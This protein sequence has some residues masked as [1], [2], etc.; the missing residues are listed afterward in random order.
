MFFLLINFVVLHCEKIVIQ[1]FVCV[2]VTAYTF[3]NY[4]NNTS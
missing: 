2:T 3:V 1:N 4:L